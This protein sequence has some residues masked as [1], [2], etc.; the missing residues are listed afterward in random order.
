MGIVIFD[1]VWELGSSSQ[2]LSYGKL[3]IQEGSSILTK[4]SLIKDKIINCICFLR[5]N[6]D[7]NKDRGSTFN[8]MMNNN[9]KNHVAP[10]RK[11]LKH[12]ILNPRD[13]LYVKKI[14]K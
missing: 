4:I 9:H 10:Y 3:G 6:A 5:H 8:L 13:P 12:E 7:N 2:V 11:C 14:K 1:I